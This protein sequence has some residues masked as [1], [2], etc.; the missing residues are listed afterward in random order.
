MPRI[1]I[2]KSKPL[3]QVISTEEKREMIQALRDSLNVSGQNDEDADEPY[4]VSK[5]DTDLLIWTAL[6]RGAQDVTRFLKTDLHDYFELLSY[7]AVT[8]RTNA[9]KIAQRL[10]Q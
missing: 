7:V 10:A 2:W 1:E 4:L 9:K 8:K 5:G 6:G 3:W